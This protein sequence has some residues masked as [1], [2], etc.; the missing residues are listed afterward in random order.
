MLAYTIDKIAQISEQ[1]VVVGSDKAGPHERRV[2]RLGSLRQEVVSPDGCRLTCLLGIVTE[3][4]GRE[5][6]ATSLQMEVKNEAHPTFRDLL[7][8]VSS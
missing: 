8:L 6:S 7:N 5:L 2:A 1:F 4:T 3:D